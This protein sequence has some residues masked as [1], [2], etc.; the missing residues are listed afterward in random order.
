MKKG[1]T[2]PR[3]VFEYAGAAGGYIDKHGYPYCRGRIFGTVEEDH[4]QYDGEEIGRA[5]V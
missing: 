5:H 2:D 4:G 1:N 3:Q